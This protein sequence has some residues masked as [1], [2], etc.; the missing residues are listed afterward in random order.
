MEVM[1]AAVVRKVQTLVRS[2]LTVVEKGCCRFQAPWV[3]QGRKGLR[4]LVV[5]AVLF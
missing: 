2:N 4:G 1:E 3:M 5:K